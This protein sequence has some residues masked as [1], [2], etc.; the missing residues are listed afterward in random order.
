MCI[1]DTLIGRTGHIVRHKPVG[2]NPSYSFCHL[3]AALTLNVCINN[4]SFSSIGRVSIGELFSNS[5]VTSLPVMRN[6]LTLC[7]K[8]RA[9]SNPATIADSLSNKA[10]T[11]SIGSVST[12][13]SK[14]VK[15]LVSQWCR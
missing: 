10:V 2:I 8:D 7:V 15:C 9:Y 11:G 5:I 3:S 13:G 4:T 1:L 12:S 14:R 6:S